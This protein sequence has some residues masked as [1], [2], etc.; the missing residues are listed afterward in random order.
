MLVLSTAS[1]VFREHEVPLLVVVQLTPDPDA[2]VAGVYAVKLAL[3]L[4]VYLVF[5]ERLVGSN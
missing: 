5:W 1:L 4:Y 3:P 2:D